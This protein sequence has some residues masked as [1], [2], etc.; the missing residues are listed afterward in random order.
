[1]PTERSAEE[2][3][4]AQWPNCAMI[5]TSRGWRLVTDASDDG[6]GCEVLKL[7]SSAYVPE[8]EAWDAAARI[9]ASEKEPAP[10]AGDQ[11]GPRSARGLR[12]TSEESR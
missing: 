4:R 12:S 1:M 3:V 8:S 11:A 9:K 5:W 7:T 6:L 10:S 2:I